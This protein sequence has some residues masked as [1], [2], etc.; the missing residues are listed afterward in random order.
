[1]SGFS[2]FF[3]GV[4]TK[5]KTAVVEEQKTLK[6]LLTEKEKPQEPPKVLFLIYLSFLTFKKKPQ[7][8]PPWED[9]PNSLDPIVRDEIKEKILS[10]TKSK[11]N[12]L[13]APPG[14]SSFKEY[15]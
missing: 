15:K 12:F 10:I 7:V 6:T 13:N 8:K 1:M 14:T 2:S 5:I 11:R 3:S 9:L 4:A